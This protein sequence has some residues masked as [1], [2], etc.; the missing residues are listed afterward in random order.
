MKCKL[1]FL[2][3]LFRGAFYTVGASVPISKGLPSVYL[4]AGI[5]AP[6]SCTQDD[7]GQVYTKKIRNHYPIVAK[8]AVWHSISKWTQ[9]NRDAK[10]NLDAP[11]RAFM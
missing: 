3:C 5:C 11:D 8:N 4:K 1:F 9:D 6:D 2:L 10:K 7:I